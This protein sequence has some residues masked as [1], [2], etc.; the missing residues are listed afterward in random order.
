MVYV[1]SYA[2]FV[3]SSSE[4]FNN[5]T[6]LQQ[7]HT[8]ETF[9][10]Q[11]VMTAIPES[12]AVPTLVVTVWKGAEPWMPSALN[13]ML[14][15]ALWTIL[16]QRW[17]LDHEE[18]VRWEQQGNHLLS[19]DND[20]PAPVASA[21]TMEG[22]KTEAEIHRLRLRVPTWPRLFVGIWLL[23][24][25]IDGMSHI[26]RLSGTWKEKKQSLQVRF[27][28][29]VDYPFALKPNSQTKQ[30]GKKQHKCILDS[31]ETDAASFLTDLMASL[32]L[33]FSFVIVL[34]F[35]SQI[36]NCTTGRVGFLFCA[37]DCRAVCHLLQDPH[38]RP[39]ALLF[40]LCHHLPHRFKIKHAA[41]VRGLFKRTLTFKGQRSSDILRRGG[42][43]PCCQDDCF[44]C[45]FRVP[46]LGCLV[47][48]GGFEGARCESCK[49]KKNTMILL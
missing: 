34:T 38:P 14:G 19:A 16:I 31:P 41:L 21:S 36:R 48:G 10:Q 12:T 28:W 17:R 27:F 32:L 44:Q 46:S 15:Y 6:T 4:R 22:F 2:Y 13:M 40:H 47:S 18:E 24:R 8:L 29:V 49:G 43:F 5:A 35:V 37:R 11:P 20:L 33:F 1:Y 26:S 45:I 30:K 23:V 42:L 9:P 25:M 7:N 39:M 3:P